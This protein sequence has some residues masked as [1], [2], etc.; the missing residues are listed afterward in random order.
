LIDAGKASGLEF[1]GFTTQEGFLLALG[2]ANQF[3]DVHDPGATEVE[4]L[5]ARLKLKRLIS[6][7]GMGNIFKVFVQ[8]RGICKVGL[9][10]LKFEK[11]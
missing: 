10:G 1:A 3:A 7:E 9:T 8:Q 11:V 6:P 2:E 4:M 5:Q